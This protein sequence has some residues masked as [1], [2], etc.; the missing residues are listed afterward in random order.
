MRAGSRALGCNKHRPYSTGCQVA[1]ELSWS[2]HFNTTQNP[3]CT[4]SGRRLAGQDRKVFK[5]RM[6]M[7][8]IPPR[9]YRCLRP[10][11]YRNFPSHSSGCPTA[12]LRQWGA[13]AWL[14]RRHAHP[15]P[16]RCGRTVISA[17]GRGHGCFA[18]A[19][20]TGPAPGPPAPEAGPKKIRPQRSD[21]VR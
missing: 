12:V 2:L 21:P 15:I 7:E 9:P 5:N 20:G 13:A 19:G 4:G 10:P 17:G 14:Y 8:K 6:D 18:S 1:W 16:S 11:V 3:D